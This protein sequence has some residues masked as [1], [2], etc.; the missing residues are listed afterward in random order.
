MELWDS[1]TFRSTATM[2]PATSLG[3]DKELG[4]IEV[5]KLADLVVLDRNPLENI[6]YTDSVFRVVLN[7]R[8]YDTSLAEIGGRPA[9]K[10]WFTGR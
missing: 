1:A 4:S 10:V 7:G 5:G 3:L 6:R 2:N 8:V 9:P